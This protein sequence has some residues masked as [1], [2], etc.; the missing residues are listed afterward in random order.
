MLDDAEDDFR[1]RACCVFPIL[2][3]RC[4]SRRIC[5]IN[6]PIMLD[7]T[8][9]PLGERRESIH[10]IEFIQRQGD[11]G[12]TG[13]DLEHPIEQGILGL[14]RSGIADRRVATH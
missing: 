3:E 12:K 9:N 2:E 11:S 5:M 8:L 6:S 1:R 7:G 13:K 10:D 4:Q 14:T